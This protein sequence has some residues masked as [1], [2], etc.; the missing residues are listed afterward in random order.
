MEVV[1]VGVRKGGKQGEGAS[2]RKATDM[3]REEDEKVQ[4]GVG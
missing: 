3:E 1:V 4:E 2:Q